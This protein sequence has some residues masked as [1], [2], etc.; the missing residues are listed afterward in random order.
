MVE[1]FKSCS[2]AFLHGK[3]WVKLTFENFLPD[4]LRLEYRS[5]LLNPKWADE[6]VSQGSGNTLI[7]KKNEIQK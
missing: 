5:K 2:I 3:I 6:M 4:V 1:I 7:K